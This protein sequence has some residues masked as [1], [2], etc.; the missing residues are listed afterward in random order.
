MRLIQVL[1]PVINILPERVVRY[2]GRRA[3]V[4]I[5]N[6]YA[7]IE[8][9]GEEILS[10]R[11]GKPTIFIA[12]H[13]SNMDGIVLNK[14]LEKNNVT[15]MAGIKLKANPFTSI[16]LR[17]VRHIPINPNSAD[18]KPIKKALEVLKAGESILIF[19]EGTRS[20]SGSMIKAKKGFLLLARLSGADIVPIAL[21]GTERLMPINQNDMGREVPHHA[22]VRVK[23]GQPFRIEKKNPG[24][25]SDEEYLHNAMRKIAE[26][27]SP[28]YQ[29]VYRIY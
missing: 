21:E 11:I 6:K 29:G 1:A 19:P 20:R 18:R 5:L 27:L 22:T 8:V 2:I 25:I 12:N 14:V 7:K 26:M 13:L 16:F 4:T 3:A 24:G 9:T 28:E 10:E 15:F 17:T 23:V